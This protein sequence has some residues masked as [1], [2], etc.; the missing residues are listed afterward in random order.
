M[1]SN[2]DG[3]WAD[4]SPIVGELVSQKEQKMATTIDLRDK[5]RMAREML[6]LSQRD[7]ADALGVDHKAISNWENGVNTPSLGHRGQILAWLGQ[8]E[9]KLNAPLPSAH[10]ATSDTWRRTTP[11][12][13]QQVIERLKEGATHRQIKAELHILNSF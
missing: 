11:T 13:K 6:G 12:L 2:H 1:T 10:A 4:D 8:V 5:V 3:E 7:V 9:Q